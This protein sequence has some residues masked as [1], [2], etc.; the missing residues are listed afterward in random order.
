MQTHSG[1]HGV[2]PMLMA[3]Y[4]Q[5]G[6]LDPA[7]LRLQVDA[8]IACGC[9]GIAILGLATD[10]NKLALEE[11]RQVLE[12][13]STYLKGRLPLSVTVAENTPEGQTAFSEL[14]VDLG[15]DWIILQPPPAVEVDEQE[16][17]AFFGAT[18]DRLSVPVGIQNAPM[19]L[20][21][22]LSN[23]GLRELHRRH[24]QLKIVKVEDDPLVI[25]RLIEETH[26]ELDVFVGRDGMEMIDLL[27]A[28]AAGL[29]PGFE[30]CDRIASA[31]RQ[32][33]NGDQTDAWK[34][35]RE[36]ESGIVF[37]ERSINHYVTY[38]REIAA[39]RL[40]ISPIIHR[41]PKP[42]SPLGIEI[43][44]RVASDLGPFNR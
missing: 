15:A 31:Y 11:R 20:Q 6:K 35:Y 3:F 2:Y 28:G 27:N 18:I 10:V 43:A 36:V 37:L 8:A 17:I 19:Y 29:I 26:G 33:R 41:L 5:Q 7:G 13:V 42:R 32:Y 21:I 40:G 44:E 22:G 38:A 9:E 12:I 14:A 24:P 1:F 23:A 4:D 34:S 16:L 39:R 25:A 30:S